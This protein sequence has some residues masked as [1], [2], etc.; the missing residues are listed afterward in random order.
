VDGND[1]GGRKVFDG[2]VGVR[3]SRVEGNRKCKFEDFKIGSDCVSKFLMATGIEDEPIRS[4]MIFNILVPG[5][6]SNQK[7]F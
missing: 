2:K 7:S 1:L 5:K 3:L 4:D 6:V